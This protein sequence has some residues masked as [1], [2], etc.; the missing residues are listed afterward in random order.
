MLWSAMKD[1][2]DARRGRNDEVLRAKILR[3]SREA[4]KVY[5]SAD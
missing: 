3:G 2:D 1:L 4:K 5:W